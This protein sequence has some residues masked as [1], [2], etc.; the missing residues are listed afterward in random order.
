MPYE[1]VNAL[2]SESVR[3]ARRFVQAFYYVELGIDYFRNLIDSFDEIGCYA[4]GAFI[5][6]MVKWVSVFR[7]RGIVVGNSSRFALKAV[8]ILLASGYRLILNILLVK[9][10]FEQ[11]FHVNREVM[12]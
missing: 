1:I 5:C 3:L 11:S 9:E 8:W 2:I 12:V 6:N 10:C 4:N 7:N